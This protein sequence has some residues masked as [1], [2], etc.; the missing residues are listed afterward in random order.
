MR[1]AIGLAIVGLVVIVVALFHTHPEVFAKSATGAATHSSIDAKRGTLTP[2]AVLS[3]APPK[4]GAIETTP[5]RKLT[6]AL[7]EF[8][9]AKSYAAIYARLSKSTTRTGEENWMLAQILNRCAKIAENEPERFKQSKLGTPEARTRFAA[10]LGANDP[11]RDKRLAAFDA[12]N[13]DSCGELSNIETSRK[14]L[15]VLLQAGADAGDPKAKASLVQFDL[16]EQSR[17]PDGKYR[18]DQSQPTKISD[19]QIDT[20][21]QVFAS[22]DPYAMRTAFMALAGSS[23]GNF[24]LRDAEDRPLNMGSLWQAG[25]L[26]GCEY[27]FDCGPNAQWIQNGCAFQ[28]YCAANNLSDYMMYYASSPHSSQMIATY[29]N[30]IRNAANNGDWSYFHFYPGPNPTTAAYQAPRNP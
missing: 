21:K 15:R 23:Y 14:D 24:S 17:G 13:F 8:D 7:Q 12:V 29:E 27:G 3:I 10:S 5:P 30:A 1:L 16:N 9:D 20:L 26:I 2:D 4:R 28:G 25:M 6:P 22:G 19:S 18:Y 11:D